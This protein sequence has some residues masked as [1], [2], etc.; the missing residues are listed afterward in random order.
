MER[1]V[2]FSLVDLVKRLIQ[3]RGEISFK[4]GYMIE[5]IDYKIIE[6]DICFT[7]CGVD[8]TSKIQSMKLEEFVTY[9]LPE[10]KGKKSNQS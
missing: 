7:L 8:S 4:T 3:E 6:E 1:T 9:M 10:L 2:T 5:Y